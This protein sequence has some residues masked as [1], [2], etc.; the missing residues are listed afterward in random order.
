MNNTASKDAWLRG[1]QQ[2]MPRECGEGMPRECEEEAG[3]VPR[4]CEKNT[5]EAGMTD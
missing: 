1:R 4:E 3:R 5:G 2:R